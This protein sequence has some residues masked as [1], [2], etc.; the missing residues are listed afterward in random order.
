M[1]L[2]CC[3]IGRDCFQDIDQGRPEVAKVVADDPLHLQAIAY[4]VHFLSKNL[5]ERLWG[6]I[7]SLGCSKIPSL[8]A[9]GLISSFILSQ[10]RCMYEMHDFSWNVAKSTYMHGEPGH[11]KVVAA[12]SCHG[13][14]LASNQDRST[15]RSWVTCDCRCNA[16]DAMST[17]MP[18]MP[19]GLVHSAFLAF[20]GHRWICTG[21]VNDIIGC[22]HVDGYLV[23]QAWPGLPHNLHIAV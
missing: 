5:S 4:P 7:I 13:Q 3:F 8:R 21:I 6:E 16:Y 10:C 20:L 14:L 12:A 9:K 11:G 22:C 15:P 19:L 1:Q 18:T 2:G 23:I 17:T